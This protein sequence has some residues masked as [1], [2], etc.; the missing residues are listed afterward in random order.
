M[1]GGFEVGWEGCSK[2]HVEQ[3]LQFA[4][5]AQIEREGDQSTSMSEKDDAFE[6]QLTSL[7]SV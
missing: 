3:D 5:L 7:A 4:S 2:Q 1:E 6:H